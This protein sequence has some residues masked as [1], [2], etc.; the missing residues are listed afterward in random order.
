MLGVS[1]SRGMLRQFIRYFF[2]NLAIDSP[3]G[4]GLLDKAA[5]AAST[6]TVVNIFFLHFVVMVI[7]L[8][9]LNYARRSFPGFAIGALSCPDPRCL[10]CCAQ[11]DKM[12]KGRAPLRPATPPQLELGKLETEKD[13]E[14]FSRKV[15]VQWVLPVD[16]LCV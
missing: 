10:C 3:V 2:S 14:E 5:P 1:F 8:P 4:H 15:N 16:L 13:R 11:Q 9:D 7:L 12:Q 6:Q